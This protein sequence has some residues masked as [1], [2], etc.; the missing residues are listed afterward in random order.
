MNM[1]LVLMAKAFKLNY[2]TP[3]NNNQRI[4]SNL[5]NRQIAQPCI[6]MG[7]DRQMQMV[8]GDGGN[9]FRV[10][11]AGNQ[12]G[13]IGVQENR[14]Q[15]QIENGNLVAARAEGNA[16]GKNRNQIR[17]YNCRG[18]EE[19]DLMAATADLDEIKE[20][21]ANCIL[22]ANL[23][24]VSTSE[25]QYTELL[26]PIPESHQNLAIKVEKVNSVNRKLKETNADLTTELA[27]YKNQERCFEISQEKYDKLER[28]YQQSVY[29]EQCLSKKINALHLS[30]ETLQLAQESRDKMKQ[31]NKEIKPTN[32]TKINHLLRVFVP[33][34][35]LSREKLYFSNNSKTANVSK[36]F[37]IPNKDLSD[38]TTPIAARKFLNE[39]KSTIVTLQRVVKQRMTIETHNWASSA[40]QELHKIEAAKFVGDFKSLANETDASL[41]K[42]KALE[43][44]IERLLKAVVSQ[45][46]MIMVQ[47]ESV[48]DTSDLQTELERTKERF[49]ICIIKKENEY[50]KLWNDWYKKCKRKDTSSVSDTQNPLSRK[51]K[52]ENVEL[53]FQKIFPKLVRQTLCENQSLQTQFLHHKN[54]K[55]KENQEKDKIGSKPDK[56]EKP[57]IKDRPPMLAP[58]NYIQW[59]SR[60][61]RYIDTKPNRELIY[62]CLKNPPYELGWNDKPVLDSEGNPTTASER[63]FGT[64]KNVT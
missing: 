52:N 49:E 10:Q 12:N 61:K 41:A 34:T 25:E 35:A 48:V 15:N 38:D 63:V 7:Q 19:Y 64:Y 21:N 9:Q 8:G 42:H 2:S 23:Q 30:T 31:M 43:L 40:H 56:N 57:G 44:E 27:R 14:N 11:N 1:A 32:Y 20:V 37:S 58:G 26:E 45:D 17:C 53:E 33:Q 13:L 6:N 62:Y 22:M 54:Q 5:R 28:C 46:I 60:I 50:A 24:Q 59:K 18:V 47:N 29:Q 4:S 55:V 16:A 51:L 3:T 36:S 39:V